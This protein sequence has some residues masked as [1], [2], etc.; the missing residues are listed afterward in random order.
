MT[1]HQRILIS[2]AADNHFRLLTIEVVH[3]ELSKSSTNWLQ[4]LVYCSYYQITD[5]FKVLILI[6]IYKPYTILQVQNIGYNF[7]TT[8]CEF[9]PYYNVSPGPYLLLSSWTVLFCATK[10]P[11]HH[12]PWMAWKHCLLHLVVQN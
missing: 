1:K 7:V 2:K 3:N 9:L 5:I 11:H 12:S 10:A 4:C 6:L 8:F